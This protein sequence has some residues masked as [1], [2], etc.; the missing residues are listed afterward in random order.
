MQTRE[1]LEARQAMIWAKCEA[2][3]AA[4]RR[5]VADNNRR[6]K[7]QLLLDKIANKPKN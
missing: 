4:L 3:I 1:R 6:E 7:A 2:S 5:R